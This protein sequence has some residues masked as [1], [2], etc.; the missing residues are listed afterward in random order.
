MPNAAINVA[1]EL[2]LSLPAFSLWEI[3]RRD[4]AESHDDTIFNYF[5]KPVLF[6]EMATPRP[7]QQHTGDSTSPCPHLRDLMLCLE[8][9]HPVGVRVSCLL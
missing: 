6:S 4:I 2:P 9:D 3:V 8:V 7:Y 1:V 5:R